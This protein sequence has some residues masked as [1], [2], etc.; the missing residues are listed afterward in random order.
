V[1]QAGPTAPA[2]GT[3]AINDSGFTPANLR[4]AVGGT[5]T[6]AN[7]GK[8][9][10]TV[11][12]TNGSFDSDMI[13]SGATWAHT[14]STAGT[15]TYNCILHPTMKGTIEVVA[16]GGGSASAAGAATSATTDSQANSA[17][18]TSAATSPTDGAIQPVTVDV[19]DNEFKPNHAIVAVGGTVTWK[20][21]GAAAHT[22]TA[23]DQSFNSGLVKPGESYSNTF[24]TLGTFTYACLVHPG[25]TGTIEVV[26]P[27]QAAAQQAAAPT[28]GTPQAQQAASA[29]QTIAA[30]GPAHS[31]SMWRDTLLGIA[32]ALLACCALVFTLK[33]FLK[34]LG[35]N[36]PSD[37]LSP[38]PI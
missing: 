18:T 3:V 2:S 13:K 34:V 17:P 36:E 28:D 24:S 4:V 9:M 33:S 10:H 31:S 37:T 1:T 14:F 12:A 38:N 21:V 25:M 20:L 6:F 5:V 27:E 32:A 35:S 7:N 15:F 8:A 16:G 26:P 22:I 30:T 29:P 23:T 19:V 11:T